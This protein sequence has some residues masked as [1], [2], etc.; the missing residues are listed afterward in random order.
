MLA[1]LCVAD[2][3]LLALPPLA[4]GETPAPAGAR[5]CE[6][7]PAALPTLGPVGFNLFGV[8]DIYGRGTHVEPSP[9]ADPFVMCTAV[10]VPPGFKLPFCAHP[11]CGAS[12][13]SIFFQGGAILPWDNVQ[14]GEPEPLLPGGI[15]HVNTGAGCVHD[16]PME[17]ISL[18]PL[19]QPGFAASEPASLACDDADPKTWM[20]Q[21]W[22]NAIDMEAPVGT[23][24]PPVTSQVV[25]PGDVPRDVSGAEAG[26]LVRC[27]AGEYR[28][29][30]NP[31]AATS[32]HPVLLL[33]V[34]VEP[35]ADGT[36]GPLPSDF[37]GFAWVLDGEA[38][39]GDGEGAV[40]ATHS[41]ERGL[42]LLPPGGDVL[43]VRS[44]PSAERPAQIFIGL[45]KPHRRPYIKYVGYGGAL[46]HRS[47]D[48]AMS[49][50][51][52]YENDPKNFGRAAAGA[53][54]SRADALGEME[55]RYELVGGFQSNG[56]EMMERPEGV[57]A[58]FKYRE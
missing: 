10:K 30:A 44:L 47:V 16:E 45:G 42:V 5:S 26:L 12:V 9:H 43:R 48:E 13:A 7:I 14:G 23:P 36:I 41:A 8:H 6:S 18:R 22:W 34:R 35:Q 46:V 4:E 11:H 39:L 19:T 1:K 25:A 54:S 17:P 20:M 15:Y 49:K 40:H 58:R 55:S 27:L 3:K 24:L 53:A 21:L 50:M 52:E 56:G 29:C 31:L 57:A 2:P 38:L 32:R 33:H 28:G 51:S 37:N